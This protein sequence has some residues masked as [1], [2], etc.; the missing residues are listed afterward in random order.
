[1]LCRGK[2]ANRLIKCLINGTFLPTLSPSQNIFFGTQQKA[3]ESFHSYSLCRGGRGGEG[4]V[5]TSGGRINQLNFRGENVSHAVFFHLHIVHQ[6]AS[7]NKGQLNV[8]ISL[9]GSTKIL[10]NECHRFRSGTEFPLSPPP[11]HEL[12]LWSDSCSDR[13]EE[14]LVMI[15]IILCELAQSLSRALREE[16]IS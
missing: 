5:N 14:L 2:S 1:M 11:P 16:N 9:C 12:T 13:D 6:S 3:L 4:K 10:I 8:T 7:S 15:I